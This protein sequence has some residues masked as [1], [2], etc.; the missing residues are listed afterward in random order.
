MSRVIRALA[1]TIALFAVATASQGALGQTRGGVLRLYHFDSPASMSILEEAGAVTVIPMMAVFN[2][3]VLYDQH[4]PQNSLQG[5]VPDLATEWSWDQAGTALTFKLRHGVEWHDGKPFTAAD[6]KCTWDLL[7]GMGSDKLRLNPRKSW[8]G[9]LEEVTTHAN[10]DVT[11]RLKRPQPAFIA[12]LASGVA[13][14]YPC[15]VRARDMR[16]HPIGTGP[17][18][19]AE[20]KPNERITLTKNINYW[21]KDRPYLD[22]I[23]YTIIRNV[24]TANLVFTAG[25]LDMTHPVFMQIPVLRDVQKADPEAICQ[26]VPSNVSRNLIINR[27][28]PPFD[29][30]E[31][32]RAMSLALD[33]KA[34]VDIL[35]GG[36]GD[37]GGTMLPPPEGVWGMP[38][39]VLKT[40][41]GY[42]PD[43]RK[44]RDAA[45]QMME[46]LGYGPDNRLKVKVSVRNI[47]ITRDPAV[48]LIDQLKEIYID[49]ELDVVESAN[50]FP[51]VIRKDY[52][53]GLNLTGKSVDDPDQNFYENYV[54]GA[55][56]NYDGYCNHKIDQLID[57]QSSESD[58]EK[59]RGMVWEIERKLADD[60]ARPIIFYPRAATC[61]HPYVKGVNVM[62][63]SIYN[64]WRFEDV[65]LDR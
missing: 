9:N 63:N 8:Y 47:P 18:K 58:Q 35:T 53:I 28:A 61:W 31:L 21:K 62:V 52:S 39:D 16:Q 41:P 2:N 37:I 48:I 1:V 4:V 46:K 17:F 43:V 27:S 13:P 38:R 50:W 57:E 22:G 42:D 5:M 34:F 6:V 32:R 54:C 25:D 65:W 36:K 51:K 19:L 24:S 30:P 45:R 14:I 56:A 3:L 26:I 23:E 12:L 15:H 40:L 64:G 20:Y 59:R 11:F 49:G 44:N 29:S 10:D 60:G 55:E 33:R 7:M